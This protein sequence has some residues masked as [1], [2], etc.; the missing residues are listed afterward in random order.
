MNMQCLRSAATLALLLCLAACGGGG[1]G[2]N[3]GGGTPDVPPSTQPE[4]QPEQ[5]QEP[6][7]EPDPDSDPAQ[8]PDPIPSV[9]AIGDGPFILVDQFG[10]QP[11]RPKIAVLRDPLEGYDSDDEYVPGATIRVVNSLDNA[12]AFTGTATQWNDGATDPSSGDRAWLFDF[13]AV[14]TPG[15]YEIV[16]GDVRSARFEI[17]ANIYRPILVQAVRTF[18]YQRAGHAK[19]AQ[20][21]GGGWADEASHLG[22]LQDAN[23][24]HY[25]APN[26]PATE[27]DLHG[28]WY[29]AGD[30]NKYSSWAAGYVTDLLHAYSENQSIWTDDFNIPESGNGVPDLLDEVKWGL[31]WLVRMQENDGSVLSIV[32]LSSASPPSNATQP[33]LYGDASTSATL[34]AAAAY[35]YSAKVFGALNTPAFNAYATDLA[36]RA[37]RAWD[38]ASANPNVVFFNND[39]DS[40]TTGLG[41]GQQETDDAGRAQK[42]LVAAIYLYDL[43]GSAT[44]R[45]FVD[46]HYTEAPMFAIPDTRSRLKSKESSGNRRR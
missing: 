25:S 13:S 46:A 34:S 41:A 11:D 27:R 32:G 2:D 3:E 8:E 26:D 1:G 9:T 35:A 7:P 16:D 17:G 30:F 18:F 5:E 31:D 36:Q 22:T 45:E 40:G 24:R 23:A 37:E 42:R 43:T 39:A 20:F 38:W 10:Y 33:S 12:V 15:S 6:A 19:P 29:D 14:T 21:A 4:P 44:Y 28:G